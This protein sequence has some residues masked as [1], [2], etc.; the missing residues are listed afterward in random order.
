M[1][2]FQI[3]VSPK[4]R[5]AGRFVN[6][7]RRA[8][9]KAYVEEQADRGLTQSD[10]ARSLGVHRSVISRE[11]RG[12]KDMNIGRVGE[13]AWALGREALF[14]LPPATQ[15]AGANTVPVPAGA[16]HAN[17]ESVTGSLMLEAGAK[18]VAMAA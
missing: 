16:V 12:Q 1:A 9:Q 6:R 11:L 17:N 18:T 2:S 7:V 4:R 10:I 3:S 15:A 13:L 5:A 8:I 14:D